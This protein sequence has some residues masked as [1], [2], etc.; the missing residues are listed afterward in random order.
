MKTINKN[1]NII[2]E[3]FDGIRKENSRKIFTILL[4]I[5]IIDS[6]IE[7]VLGISSNN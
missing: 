5:I 4:I 7:C 6:V 3:P 1:E 2:I